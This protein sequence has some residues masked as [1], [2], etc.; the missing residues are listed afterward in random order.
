M[1]DQARFHLLFEGRTGRI[2][3]SEPMEGK[4]KGK[5]RSIECDESLIDMHLEQHLTNPDSWTLGFYPVRD[6]G[7]CKWGCYDFDS[8]TSDPVGDAQTCLAG[9]QRAGLN[10]VIE[11][12]RSGD[13]RHVWVFAEDWVPA[14]QMRAA[15]LLIDEALELH[16]NEINPKQKIGT[17]Y[18][19]TVGN[20]VRLPYAAAY[21]EREE[22]TMVAHDGEGEPYSLSEFLDIADYARVPVA[23]IAELASK[24]HPKPPPPRRVEFQNRGGFRISEDPKQDAQLILAGNE[25]AHEGGFVDGRNN[26]LWSFACYLAAHP[27][28]DQEEAEHAMAAVHRDQLVQEPDEI[29]LAQCLSMVDRAFTMER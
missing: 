17:D 26:K 27:R 7:M 14:D 15:L 6:D 22:P 25:I 12:S 13:G 19:Q 28:Y 1:D 29:S 11:S 24:W 2:G 16:C 23:R 20:Y 3:Q 10:G 8:A 4:L 18:S 5:E 21:A 9:L